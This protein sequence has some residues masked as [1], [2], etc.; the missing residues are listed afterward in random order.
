[1]KHRMV[2]IMMGVKGSD[3]VSNTR[4]FDRNTILSLLIDGATVVSIHWHFVYLIASTLNLGQSSM[5]EETVKS[6]IEV[7]HLCWLQALSLDGWSRR[8]YNVLVYEN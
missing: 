1:M 5:R 7:E 4:E 2:A 6:V 3:C 8:M